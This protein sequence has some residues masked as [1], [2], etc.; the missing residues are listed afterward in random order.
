MNFLQ[1][2]IHFVPC[3]FTNKKKNRTDRQIFSEIALEKKKQIVQKEKKTI[4][5]EKKIE[6]VNERKT[7]G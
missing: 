7:N 4:K 3:S 5:D 2:N 1:C 6:R